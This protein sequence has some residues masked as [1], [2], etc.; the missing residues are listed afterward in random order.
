MLFF[1]SINSY[2]YSK[3]FRVC[4]VHGINIIIYT[5]NVLMLEN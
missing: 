5:E 2:S 3:Y 1:S 4:I